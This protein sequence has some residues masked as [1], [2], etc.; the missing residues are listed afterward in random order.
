MAPGAPHVMS[1]PW[2]LYRPRGNSGRKLEREKETRQAPAC[3]RLNEKHSA[4]ASVRPKVCPLDV[5]CQRQGTRLRTCANHTQLVAF[6]LLQ[7]Y[8]ATSKGSFFMKVL[9]STYNNG[10]SACVCRWRVSWSFTCVCTGG[11]EGV[12]I[13]C[14]G[15]FAV[16]HVV[17][18]PLLG[19]CSLYVTP[20]GRHQSV[21]GGVHKGGR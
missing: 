7:P 4:W 14:E 13:P 8:P 20:L 16:W 15:R 1:G 10:A 17:S 2:H 21:E 9:T 12:R 19:Q 3:C 5:W 6:V 11:R 18:V